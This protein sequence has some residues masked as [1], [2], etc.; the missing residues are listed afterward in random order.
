MKSKDRYDGAV[1][2]NVKNAER[3]KKAGIISPETAN[4]RTSKIACYTGKRLEAAKMMLGIKPD[5][6]RFD[7][8]VKGLVS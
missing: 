1:E 3:R 6:A 4:G 7:E 5:D 8:R 2:R